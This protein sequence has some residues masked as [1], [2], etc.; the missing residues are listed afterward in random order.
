MTMLSYS[1]ANRGSYRWSAGFI[2]GLKHLGKKT[3]QIILCVQTPVDKC[4]KRL[5]ST[6]NCRSF[7]MK[8]N[9]CNA[10][11][12]VYMPWQFSSVTEPTY[13]YS[14]TAL[15]SPLVPFLLLKAKIT[16]LVLLVVS[17][18]CISANAAHTLKLQLWVTKLCVIYPLKK[19]K[20]EFSS[21]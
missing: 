13:L 16:S 6:P 8:S 1:P 18:S 7:C 10:T 14:C 19:K 5:Q 4:Q 20:K 12:T 17:L 21:T 15:I 11:G 3:E 9:H 2:F